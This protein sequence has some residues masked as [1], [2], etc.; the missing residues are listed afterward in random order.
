MKK[1]ISS[2]NSKLKITED[3]F[4]FTEDLFYFILRNSKRWSKHC[5]TSQRRLCHG[6]YTILIY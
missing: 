3:L 6:H 4:Y 1:V 5:Y 2:G